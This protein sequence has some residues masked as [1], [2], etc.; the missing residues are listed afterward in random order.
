MFIY[1]QIVVNLELIIANL[2]FYLHDRTFFNA[3]E[4]GHK[5]KG[6]RQWMWV[7][8]AGIISIFMVHASRSAE[9]A[10]KLLGS[11]FLGL[12]IFDL[13]HRFKDGVLSRAEFQALMKPILKINLFSQC[14][15]LFVVHVR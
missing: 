8:I 1:R 14:P 12:L 13:W 6:K 10:Q 3:D 7:A 2:Q 4:A 11:N 5:E 15:L 9:A